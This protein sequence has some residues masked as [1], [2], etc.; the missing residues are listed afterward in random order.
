MHQSCSTCIR[1][2]ELPTQQQCSSAL[3]KILL[4]TFISQKNLAEINSSSFFLFCFFISGLLCTTMPLAYHIHILDKQRNTGV[5]LQI[6]G[7]FWS[8]MGSSY[9][10]DHGYF[11]THGFWKD[12]LRLFPRLG[13]MAARWVSTSATSASAQRV[14][15]QSSILLRKHAT[16]QLPQRVEMMVF[17]RA[18]KHLW[19]SPLA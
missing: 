13:V 1:Y 9:N 10:P 7:S 3:I 12:N 2:D 14:F 16:R 18:K 5:S 15:S 19:P 17:L 8:G 11:N 6:P 4:H